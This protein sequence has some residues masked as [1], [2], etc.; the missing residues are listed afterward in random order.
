MTYNT[1]YYEQKYIFNFKLGGLY[2]NDCT[3]ENYIPIWLIGIDL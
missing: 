2:I 1:S 3:V